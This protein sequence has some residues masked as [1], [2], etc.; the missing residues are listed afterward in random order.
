MSNQTKTLEFKIF[1]GLFNAQKYINRIKTQVAP[2]YHNFYNTNLP[3]VAWRKFL[4][5]GKISVSKNKFLEFSVGTFIFYYLK[6]KFN[7]DKHI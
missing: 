5:N 4:G 6:F 1:E 3:M 2:I 7:Q